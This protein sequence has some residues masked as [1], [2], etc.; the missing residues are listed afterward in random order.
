LWS[1]VVE[2]EVE[3][4]EILVETVLVE[5]VLAVSELV[6]ICQSLGLCLLLLVLVVE[7][8]IPFL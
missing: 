5:V 7:V 4:K 8:L 3:E 2:E 1:L 6:L